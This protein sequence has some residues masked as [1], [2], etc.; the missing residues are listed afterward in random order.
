MNT[1]ELNPLHDDEPVYRMEIEPDPD[2]EIVSKVLHEAAVK[3]QRIVK[4]GRAAGDDGLLAM[5]RI[6][7]QVVGG[8]NGQAVLMRSYLLSIF[9]KT[10]A[11][12]SQVGRLDWDLRKDLCAVLL[13][14]NQGDFDDFEIR[15]LLIAAGDHNAEWFFAGV[16][17]DGED[18]S[19]QSAESV[20]SGHRFGEEGIAAM[21]RLASQI[22]GRSSSQALIVRDQ[23]R[24]LFVDDW[25]IQ[26]SDVGG[27]DP[28]LR[29]DL[30]TVLQSVGEGNFTHHL[31]R[32]L[33]VEAG[34]RNSAWFLEDGVING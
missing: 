5:K 25:R 4:E 3:L 16:P 18:E 10:L 29:K 20:A 23:L 21:K 34:D 14:V 22:V 6:A 9:G 19:N 30:C 24:S 32:D 26:L 28:H 11:D 31:I 1:P 8:D 12:L 7:T 27:L 15:E 2:P 13:G 33:L 17:N